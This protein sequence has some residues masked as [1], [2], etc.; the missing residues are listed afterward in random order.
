IG[1]VRLVATTLPDFLT[2]FGRARGATPAQIALA[3]FIAKKPFIVPIP[4]TGKTDRLRENIGAV[5]VRLTPT[6]LRELE[7]GLAK[8][9]IYGGRMDAPQMTQ[10]GWD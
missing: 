3:W 10:I 7:A 8:L 2:K 4:G 6:Y 9:E 5:Q 1:E